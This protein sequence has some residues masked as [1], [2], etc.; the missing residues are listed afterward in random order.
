MLAGQEDA[1]EGLVTEERVAS[2]ESGR[3]RL[4]GM[5]ERC[6]IARASK[7]REAARARAAIRRAGSLERGS[8]TRRRFRLRRAL[9]KRPA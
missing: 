2:S 3:P 6:G 1:L 7:R 5:S 4:H 8:H 9:R